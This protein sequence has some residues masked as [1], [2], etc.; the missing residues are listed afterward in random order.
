MTRRREP[1]LCDMSLCMR[2]HTDGSYWLD[3]HMYKMHDTHIHLFVLCTQ[4]HCPTCSRSSLRLRDLCVAFT[5]PPACATSMDLRGCM[6]SCGCGGWP[7]LLLRSLQAAKTHSTANS[8]FGHQAASTPAAAEAGQP[9]CHA[10]CKQMESMIFAGTFCAGLRQL[11]HTHM[12]A[13]V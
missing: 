12:L 1:P 13:V 8:T 10:P 3:P 2:M 11:S 4:G 6:D 5:R 7:A 9:C